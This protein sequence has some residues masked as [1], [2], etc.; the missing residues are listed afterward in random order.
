MLFSSSSSSS[1]FTTVTFSKRQ[2]RYWWPGIATLC[3]ELPNTKAARFGGELSS[4][5]RSM[6]KDPQSAR[7]CQQGLAGL[8]DN[9]NAETSTSP[10]LVRLNIPYDASA[11]ITSA[12]VGPQESI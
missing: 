9:Q 5:L 10:S 1:S 7:L 2:E 4:L 11:A 6:S 8:L 3:Q 12:T